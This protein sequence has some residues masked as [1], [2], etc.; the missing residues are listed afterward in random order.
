MKLLKKRQGLPFLM[1]L[2]VG[3]MLSASFMAVQ[4]W[5]DKEI[6]RGA[7][8]ALEAPVAPPDL[9]AVAAAPLLPP[10]ISTKTEVVA[11][12]S[13]EVTKAKTPPVAPQPKIQVEPAQLVASEPAAAAKPEKFA[14]HQPAEVKSAQVEKV[15]KVSAKKTPAVSK[16]SARKA[17]KAVEKVPTEIPPEW[18][19]FQKPLKVEM[20]SGEVEIVSLEAAPVTSD[21]VEKAS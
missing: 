8:E 16:K 6:R 21:V 3:F 9:A 12:E 7:V 4:L 20:V 14:E 13:T 18:N 2:G 5:S 11:S 15:K 17:K 10:A 1:T 19:W